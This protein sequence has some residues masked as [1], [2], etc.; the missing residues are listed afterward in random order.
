MT[1]VY[2]G[3]LNFPSKP[4]ADDDTDDNA[5]LVM[6]G[7]KLIKYI[8]SSLSHEDLMKGKTLALDKGVTGEVFSAPVVNT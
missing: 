4:V 5:H 6:D 1:G 2:V 3:E 7:V 8:G